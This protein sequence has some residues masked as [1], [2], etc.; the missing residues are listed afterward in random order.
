MRP[1]WLDLMTCLAKTP[2]DSV[3]RAVPSVALVP[4][5][6]RKISAKPVIRGKLSRANP[7]YSSSSIETLKMQIGFVSQTFHSLHF[8]QFYPYARQKTQEAMARNTTVFTFDH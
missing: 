7:R 2:G 5:V 4:G 1:V 8:N 6:T 3:S